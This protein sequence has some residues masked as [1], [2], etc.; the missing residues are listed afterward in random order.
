MG[1][2][3]STGTSPGKQGRTQS[4]CAG[5]KAELAANLPQ[6]RHCQLAELAGLLH[7][8][9]VLG[10]DTAGLWTVGFQSENPAVYRKGFTLLQKTF[11]IVTVSELE[12]KDADLLFAGIGRPE[13]VVS[14][15][16]LKNACCQRSFLRG[17]FLGAGS[18]SDPRKGYHAEFVC[19]TRE[20]AEQV[21]EIL[22]GFEIEAK[23]ILRK[24]NHV[25]YLK[26]GESIVSLLS[27]LGAPRSLM[28]QE[29]LRI[30]KE[31]NN[32]VNRRVNCEMSN[33]RKIV[34]AS[35]KQLS[36]IEFLRDHVGFDKLPEPLR[37]VAAARLENPE[38][39]L[40]ELGEI[41]D[42]P[43]GKSGVYHRLQKLG[44]IAD[45]YRCEA[46]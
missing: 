4:F 23:I 5:V 36:D 30:Y 33:I 24:K 8:A 41:L 20:K 43:V 16:L 31:V 10:Q 45:S 29:N 11:N 19:A 12:P 32:S 2:N 39:P 44:E 28:D 34:E 40:K 27:V 3:S 21:R 18:I 14:S 6:A 25:V 7:F 22:A 38:M 15:V 37:A 13:E 26:E 9:G 46:Q 35:A 42:P 1:S 17:A